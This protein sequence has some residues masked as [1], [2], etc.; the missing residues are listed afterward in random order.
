MADDGN[1]HCNKLY[2]QWSNCYFFHRSKHLDC[3]VF[4]QPEPTPLRGYRRT[5]HQ[6]EHVD[7]QSAGQPGSKPTRSDFGPQRQQVRRCRLWLAFR[8]RLPWPFTII[9]PRYRAPGR[10]VFPGGAPNGYSREST[11]ESGGSHYMDH[12]RDVNGKLSNIIIQSIHCRF[13]YINMA[14][15]CRPRVWSNWLILRVKIW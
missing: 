12:Y 9:C 14:G 3:H 5:P 15:F 13:L 4:K 11:P 1:W 7:V 2:D 10:L 8:G 6:P